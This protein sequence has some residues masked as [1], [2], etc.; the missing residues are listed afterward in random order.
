MFRRHY[1][2]MYVILSCLWPTHD[3]LEASPTADVREMELLNPDD[4]PAADA[5]AIAVMTRGGRVDETLEELPSLGILQQ[6]E[7]TTVSLKNEYGVLKYDPRA[8]AIVAQSKTGFAFI[9]LPIKSNVIKLR[10]WAKLKVDLSDLTPHLNKSHKVYVLWENCFAGHPMRPSGSDDPFG[11]DPFANSNIPDVD[12]RFD[13]FIQWSLELDPKADQVVNVPMGEVTLI[14]TEGDMKE[15]TADKGLPFI[16]YKPMRTISGRQTS[17]KTPPFETIKG[18]LVPDPIFPPGTSRQLPNWTVGNDSGGAMVF[19]APYAEEMP[20]IFQSLF[21]G[22]DRGQGTILDELARRYASEVGMRYRYSLPDVAAARIDSDGTFQLANVPAG[23]YQLQILHAASPHAPVLLKRVVDSEDKPLV[24]ELT[25]KAAPLDVGE[26]ERINPV[27]TKAA[28]EVQSQP[29]SPIQ[30]PPKAGEYLS[31]Q[32]AEEKIRKALTKRVE[33]DFQGLPL[34]MVVDELASR[35][36]TPIFLHEIEL[37]SL[38]IKLDQPVSVTLP[39]MTLQSAL[40][41]MLSTISNDVTYTIR[42]EVVLIT[43]KEDAEKDQPA[44]A[45]LRASASTSV[46]LDTGDAFMQQWLKSSQ[47]ADAAAMRKALKAHLEKEFDAKQQSR[48]TE[49]ARL[50][51]LLKQSEEWLEN[52]QSRKAEIV[53]KKMAELLK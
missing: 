8:I 4:S 14:V 43:S 27:I 26:L 18:K 25:G 50:K 19:A 52:R 2:L 3:T 20:E 34:R 6:P 12:W 42:N 22:L 11:G 46:E 21:T 44:I 29:Q 47:A 5:Q 39:D 40:R 28:P 37:Q 36:G 33:V 30:A 51:T 16:R 17:F 45:Q 35:S 53:E 38:G 24:V 48:Q 9:P 10:P 1:V 7:G 15:A 41:N 32:E 13:N 23:K 49:I 31:V